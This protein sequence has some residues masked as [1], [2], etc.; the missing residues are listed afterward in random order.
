M[1]RPFLIEWPFAFDLI[2]GN[3]ICYGSGESLC[4]YSIF[5]HRVHLLISSKFAVF[6]NLIVTEFRSTTFQ[7]ASHGVSRIVINF[8]R[9][10][11][12]TRLCHCSILHEFEKKSSTVLLKSS[13]WSINV[14]CPEHGTTQ[15]AALGMFW[16]I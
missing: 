10:R 4:E 2:N 13:A 7:T 5:D 1:R 15:S 16:K 11:C 12:G 6:K 9:P 8:C 14:E 3:Y